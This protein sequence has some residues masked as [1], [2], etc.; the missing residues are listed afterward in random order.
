VLLLWLGVCKQVV[1]ASIVFACEAG[2]SCVVE[3][4]CVGGETERQNCTS[5]V[6]ADGHAG[7][8]DG[9]GV[10]LAGNVERAVDTRM[11]VPSGSKAD[12]SACGAGSVCDDVGNVCFQEDGA[13]TDFNSIPNAI[14]WSLVST[15]TVTRP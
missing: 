1:M 11:W 9:S 2:G 13:V 3:Y 15:T 14:W 7:W 6:F 10:V 12:Q 4:R 8:L 5:L